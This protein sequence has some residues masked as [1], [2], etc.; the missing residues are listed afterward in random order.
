MVKDGQVR[1]LMSLLQQEQSLQVAADKAGM[2]RQTAR[3][4]QQLGKLPSEV[5]TDRDW[6]TRI[7]PFEEV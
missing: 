2:D 4:Y 5:R 1:R 7:D 6:R 3:K